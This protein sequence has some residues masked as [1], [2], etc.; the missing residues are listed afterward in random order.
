MEEV[1]RMDPE[2]QEELYELAREEGDEVYTLDYEGGW[3]GGSASICI[4]RGLYF[5][6]ADYDLINNGPFT[7]FEEALS[8]SGVAECGGPPSLTCSEMDPETLL[9]HITIHELDGPVEVNGEMWAW[10]EETSKWRPWNEEQEPADP[11]VEA[12]AAQPKR[13]RS[14]RKRKG[15]S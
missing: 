4:F 5:A 10:D 2:D 9:K 15:T 12:S 3:S 6:F 8:R 14:T 13:R 1:N 7:T 11:K